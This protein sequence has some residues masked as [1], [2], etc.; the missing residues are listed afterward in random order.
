VTR[1]APACL[2]VALAALTLAPL[3]AGGDDCAGRAG[4]ESYL[5][6]SRDRAESVG[7]A[8]YVK[9]RVGRFLDTR[10]LKTERA[11]NYKLAATWLTP[12]TIRAAARLQ[13]LATG[14]TADDARRQ[15]CAADLV[16]DTVVLVEIDPR[17]GSGVIPL[18]WVALLRPIL[19]DG[20]EG[21]AIRGVSRPALRDTPAL[22]GVLRRNYDYD[23]F[24]VVF[25][26]RH[27][28]GSPVLPPDA[29]QAEL[30]V[31]IYENE[32]RVSWPIPSSIRS[33]VPA[34]QA[35]P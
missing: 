15:V 30:V 29:A 23:R 16:K 7:R 34:G 5:A 21:E 27:A 26:L 8:Q 17:E 20:R 4:D 2:I 32:G 28:D 1:A 22:G 11:H 19:P 18:D 25:P 9:G 3:S 12:E 14:T 31:R 13:Q 24:W 35:V 33:L 6:W 10:W